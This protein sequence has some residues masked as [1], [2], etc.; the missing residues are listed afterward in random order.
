M[1]KDYH[2]MPFNRKSIMVI[3]NGE[4]ILRSG[5]Q[6]RSSSFEAR[7]GSIAVLDV[8]SDQRV[9]YGIFSLKYYNSMTSNGDNLVDFTFGSDRSDIYEPYIIGVDGDFVVVLRLSIFNQIAKLT[10]NLEVI[11]PREQARY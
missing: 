7:K 3:E 6:W 1:S 10:I 11:G 2:G 4:L 9:Y 5:Q 8:S